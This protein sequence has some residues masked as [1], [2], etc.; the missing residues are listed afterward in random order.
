MAAVSMLGET[1][2]GGGPVW[3]KVLAPAPEEIIPLGGLV[4]FGLAATRAPFR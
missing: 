4:F 3:V 2:D 1:A